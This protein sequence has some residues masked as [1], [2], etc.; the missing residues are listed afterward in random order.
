[1]EPRTVELVPAK[2]RAS[3]LLV[4]DDPAIAELATDLLDEAGYRVEVV[5]DAGAA[6]ET[7]RNGGHH[8]VDA[9]FSDIMMPGGM[10]GAELAEVIRREYPHIAILLTT[11]YAEAAAGAALSG[12]QLIAKPYESKAL[13]GALSQLLAAP[14]AGGRMP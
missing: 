2:T 4:E 13:V 1:M 10:N 11:G 5:G 14:R 6:L 7:L 9:V 8:R 12:F 3:I